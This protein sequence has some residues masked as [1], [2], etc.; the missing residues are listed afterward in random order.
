[1]EDITNLQKE[2]KNTLFQAAIQQGITP[3]QFSDA[4]SSLDSIG[5]FAVRMRNSKK[6]GKTGTNE[7][8]GLDSAPTP[9]EYAAF[10]LFKG[11]NDY[12]LSRG[13]P[14]VIGREVG[15]Y[16]FS[17]DRIVLPSLETRLQFERAAI[18]KG[19][20]THPIFGDMVYDSIM[21]AIPL[22]AEGLPKEDIPYLDMAEK[23]ARS[24][25]NP[26][27]HLNVYMHNIFGHK[28]HYFPEEAAQ[29]TLFMID[30]FEQG[31]NNPLRLPN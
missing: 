5:Y 31:L 30:M 18:E 7:Q 9:Y 13:I 25:M 11:V 27:S 3:K 20:E 24:R 10:A 21:Q 22:A 14:I 23:I 19:L 17:L 29:G 4:F 12:A 1:L 15:E 28:T 16:E 26:A 6:F 8:R 2:L